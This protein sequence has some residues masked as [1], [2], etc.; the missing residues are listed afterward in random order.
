MK[1]FKK[2]NSVYGFTLIELLIIVSLIGILSSAGFV[3][4]VKFNQG[5]ILNTVTEDLRSTLFSARSQ[6][7]SLTSM[8]CYGTDQA[9]A[10][11]K[12]AFC[13]SADSQ[14]NICR[15]Q[16][17]TN[18]S[19]EM[20]AVCGSGASSINMPLQIQTVPSQVSIKPD[21]CAIMFK[22]LSSSVTGFGNVTVSLSSQSKTITVNQNG[23]IQ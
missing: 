5:Q 7:L 17:V 20:D 22:P 23:A 4:T 12:V 6:T 13:N 19:Y 8:N 3:L 15:S 10:G 11:I 21:N 1:F 2:K 9:F 18:S 16:C 14:G